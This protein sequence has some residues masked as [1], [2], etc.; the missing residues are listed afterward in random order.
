MSDFVQ[1]QGCCQD[2]YN[3]TPKV[4]I[5][6]VRK[7]SLFTLNAMI[8]KVD[9]NRSYALY[10][11][12]YRVELKQSYLKQL[13]I[14]IQ[15]HYVSS[16]LTLQVSE[17]DIC[18]NSRSLF[19]IPRCCMAAWKSNS[20]PGNTEFMIAR[21]SLY[22]MRCNR[23]PPLYLPKIWAMK[24]LHSLSTSLA[25]SVYTAFLRVS[26]SSRVNVSFVKLVFLAFPST[27]CDACWDRQPHS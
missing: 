2:V 13:P 20:N 15:T 26:G 3:Y 23:P 10:V 14:R 21:I 9:T 16:S 4:I 1:T 6:K 27:V 11:M 22:E 25:S 8:Y 7:T 17:N 12:I 24:F 18:W 5:Y 19:R